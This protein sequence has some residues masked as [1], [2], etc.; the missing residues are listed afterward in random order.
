MSDDF[1]DFPIMGCKIIASI[2]W[3]F[4]APHEKQAR[5]NHGGQ[6][7]SELAGRGGLGV[8]EALAIIEGR[9]W[10]SVAVCEANDVLLINKVR[11]WRAAQRSQP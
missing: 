8:S 1:R 5:S 11:E 2:P 6:S 7:L 10:G 4:L 3:A 9:R